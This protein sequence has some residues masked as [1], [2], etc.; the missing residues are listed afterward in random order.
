MQSVVMI[1][2]CCSV[3]TILQTGTGEPVKAYGECL[4]CFETYN[5]DYAKFPKETECRQKKR[6][7]KPVGV[8]NTK[9]KQST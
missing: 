7:E 6:G 2:L 3:E 5:G 9:K 4:S 8:Q 1:C